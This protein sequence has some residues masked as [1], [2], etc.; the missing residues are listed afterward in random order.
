MQ[1]EKESSAEV[2]E[3]QDD[4]TNKTDL[5]AAGEEDNDACVYDHGFR[6]YHCP[7]AFYGDE[8][9]V[10][11]LCD[12]CY[13]KFT[14]TATKVIGCKKRKKTSDDKR[15]VCK[16]DLFELKLEDTESMIARKNRAQEGKKIPAKCSKCQKLL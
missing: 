9:C 6:I 1:G 4:H 13:N 7:L 16:H 12:R 10:Y 14:G 5:D 11:C 2:D 3:P 8:E 15:K